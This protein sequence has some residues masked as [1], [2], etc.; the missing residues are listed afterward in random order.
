MTGDGDG[1]EARRRQR[2]RR[3]EEEEEEGG[4]RRSCAVG[5]LSCQEG[6]FRIWLGRRGFISAVGFLLI[7]DSEGEFEDDELYWD[8]VAEDDEVDI[9]NET[10]EDT[11]CADDDLE[12]HEDD[13]NAVE[14]IVSCDSDV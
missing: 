9:A 12:V 6:F 14:T 7:E 5:E 8:E 10:D 11:N 13:T 3:Q 1:R 4:G 2:L